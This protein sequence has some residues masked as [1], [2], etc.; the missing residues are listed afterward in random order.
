M[1]LAL[2][3]VELDCTLRK[4]FVFSSLELALLYICTC[5]CSKQ[6]H[7]LARCSSPQ[8]VQLQMEE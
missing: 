6:Q 4:N 7:V 8:H 3:F 1:A 5:Q 2:W